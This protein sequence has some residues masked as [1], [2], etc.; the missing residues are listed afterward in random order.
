MMVEVC[1]RG[2]LK[3]YLFINLFRVVGRGKEKG[4]GAS[5]RPVLVNTRSWSFIQIGA[6]KSGVWF[7]HL[8]VDGK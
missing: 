8:V 7:S 6:C 1:D 2:R 5:F 4:V 3:Q